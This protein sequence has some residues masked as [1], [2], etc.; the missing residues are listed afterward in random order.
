MR[1]HHKWYD[2]FCNKNENILKNIAC[3]AE[4]DSLNR[5]FWNVKISWKRKQ[6]KINVIVDVNVRCLSCDYC[7]IC[8]L[9]Y[10][11]ICFYIGRASPNKYKY[12]YQYVSEKSV[13]LKEIMERQESVVSQYIS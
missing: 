3:L 5:Y 6:Y 12:N 4:R 1:I 2:M 10:H 9:Y 13:D 7:D 8:N 11:I